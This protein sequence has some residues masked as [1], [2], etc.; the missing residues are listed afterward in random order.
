MFGAF[1]KKNAQG[2][3]V[4]THQ[5]WNQQVQID[6]KQHKELLYIKMQGWPKISG[7]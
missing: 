3:A 6:I 5:I 7:F 4:G 2:L 1:Y